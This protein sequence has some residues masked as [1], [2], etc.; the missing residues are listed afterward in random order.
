M[1]TEAGKKEEDRLYYE[2]EKDKVGFLPSFLIKMHEK[3]GA[4]SAFFD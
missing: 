2:A 4:S 3:K 1:L